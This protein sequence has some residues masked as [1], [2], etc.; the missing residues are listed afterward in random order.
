MEEADI[1]RRIDGIEK[2]I[3][4]LESVD[5]GSITGPSRKRLKELKQMQEQR[6][7]QK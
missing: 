5:L 3:Q 1:Q 7:T 6:I 2:V 4:D